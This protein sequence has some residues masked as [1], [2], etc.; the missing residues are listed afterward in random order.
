MCGRFNVTDGP[1]LR[2]LLGELGI[3]LSLPTRSN[4]APTE[5]IAMVRHASEPELVA[6]RWWLTPRWARQVDQKYA[7]F[8]ARAEGLETSRA[9]SE[10]FRRRRGI[11]PMSSF[12]EWRSEDGGR[13]PYVIEAAGE[14]LAVAAVWEQWQ[15]D[16]ALV[17]SCALVTVAAAPGFQQIHNRMPL[18]LVGEERQRWLDVAAPLAANDALFAPAMKLPLRATPVSRQLNNAR[19]KDTALLAATAEPIALS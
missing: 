13:Q 7:M 6:L 18:L 9:F 11:V 8:N 1:A 19:N 10:P 2:A 3:D 14:A 16:D 17:E 5:S 12:I 4:I 15:G